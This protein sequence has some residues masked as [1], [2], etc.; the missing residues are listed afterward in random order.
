MFA[1]AIAFSTAYIIWENLY[2]GLT[3][4]FSCSSFEGESGLEMAGD[5]GGL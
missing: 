4:Y 2:S 5:L 1:S 3:T